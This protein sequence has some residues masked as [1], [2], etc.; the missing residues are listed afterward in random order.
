MSFHVPL[1]VIEANATNPRGFYESWWPVKFHLRLIKRAAIEQTDGQPIAGQLMNAALDEKARTGLHTWLGEQLGVSDLVLVK[2]PRAAWVPTLWADTAHDLGAE[3]GYVAMIR[4]PSEV[5]GS[6]ST[7]YAARRPALSDRQF[8]IRNLC[9]W[10]NQN[11]TLERE[12]RTQTRI[13]LTY[14][15]LVADWRSSLERTFEALSLP[16][17]LLTPAAEAEIDA[18]I[19]PSLRRH[20]VDWGDR[21]LPPVLVELA[22]QTW[23]ALE[24]RSRTP[25]VIDPAVTAEIDEISGRYERFYS[26]AE[27]IAHDYAA[28]RARRTLK[29]GRREGRR[30]A[31]KTIAERRWS[32]RIRRKV[33]GV[34]S[35]ARGRLVK[36]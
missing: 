20:E 1:P 25:G 8:D 22:E 28:T 18:F 23:A 2:D 36:G 26:E 6:R 31:Q 33:R 3:I 27:A 4:H 29:A 24:A 35:A 9:G 17:S 21:D 30:E 7:Y 11:L 10:I 34:L 32:R 5:V 15:D 12:T 14:A 19:E 13:Y 16:T